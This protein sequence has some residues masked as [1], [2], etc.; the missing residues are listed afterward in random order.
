MGLLVLSK[1]NSGIHVD[2]KQ[3]PEKTLWSFIEDKTQLKP[4]P[5]IT[6]DPGAGS[7]VKSQLKIVGM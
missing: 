3:Y 2:N 4:A 6:I 7:E 1:H 5:L